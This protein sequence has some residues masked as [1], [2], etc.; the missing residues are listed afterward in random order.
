MI[1]RLLGVATALL[2]AAAI[3]GAH[4]EELKTANFAGGCFWCVESDFDRVPGVVRTVSGYT[5][6][7]VVR[8]TYEQVSAGGTGH[9][10]AVQITYDPSQ[11]S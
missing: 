2:L 1:W 4:A 5:G 8:P 7:T 9:R 11:V 3:G 6:G 10:E